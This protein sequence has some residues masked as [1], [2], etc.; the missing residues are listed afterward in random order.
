MILVVKVNRLIWVQGFKSLYYKGVRDQFI[1][2]YFCNAER[3]IL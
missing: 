2:K 1:R 3:T